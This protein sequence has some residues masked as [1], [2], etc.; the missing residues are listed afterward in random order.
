M[1][2]K[3]TL[4]FCL[5]F[6]TLSAA[7]QSLQ[8]GIIYDEDFLREKFIEE[9]FEG[10]YE[11]YTQFFEDNLIFPNSSY[12]NQTEGLLLFSFS[13]NKS[14]NTV[15]TKF[16]TLLDEEIEQQI[17]EVVTK[18]ISKW[19]M[20]D[21]K[22]YTLYQPIVYSMLPYYAETLQGDIPEIP[23]DLPLKF[24]RPFILVKSK[25]IPEKFSIESL[26]EI[27]APESKRSFYE[28]AEIAYE[29]F[30]AKGDKESDYLVLNQI[31]RYN[32][33]NRDY[34]KSRIQLEQAVG[35]NKYQMYDSYLLSDFVDADANRYKGKSGGGNTGAG[36]SA[37]INDSNR[38][39][40]KNE[41]T[42]NRIRQIFDSYQGGM[43]T[44]AYD[45]ISRISYPTLSQA[46]G[47][48]G[49]C[50]YKFTIPPQGPAQFTLLT[51][52]DKDIEEELNWAAEATQ[53]KWIRRDTTF[54]EYGAVYFS[55]LQPFDFAFIEKEKTFK[56]FRMEQSFF[57]MK[58]S[59]TPSPVSISTSGMNLQEVTDA[60]NLESE[61]LRNKR[62]SLLQI[63]NY[64]IYEEYVENKAEYQSLIASGK[65]K[66]AFKVLSEMIKYNPFDRTL[67]QER[68]RLAT[69]IKKD[70]YL[71]YDEAL[72]ASLNELFKD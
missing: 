28:R 40:S 51:Y 42:I 3:H 57:R 53:N 45:F 24:L 25:R 49:I 20:T 44:F 54:H 48:T 12:K 65:S 34:L 70:Q 59:K 6:I 68:I 47:T 66:K 7:S 31:V 27:G 26:G 29:K 71:A 60:Y 1:T 37:K 17:T 23:A 2:F 36:F 38:L 21:D 19:N 64:E 10:G 62:D 69:E 5:F 18:S 13:I 22:F 32:P 11:G 35:E 4:S 16:L 30:L 46:R 15:K 56:Q 41:I 52:L 14:R 8:T 72:L 67:I 50:L 43:N 55:D 33:L 63:V 58:L 9:N 61:R 39:S